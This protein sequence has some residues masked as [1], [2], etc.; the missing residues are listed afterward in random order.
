MNGVV[1]NPILVS[2]KHIYG[3]ITDPSFEEDVLKAV[4]RNVAASR[5]VRKV[6]QEIREAAKALRVQILNHTATR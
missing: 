3:V 5:R 4:N 2:F 6:L 1:Q